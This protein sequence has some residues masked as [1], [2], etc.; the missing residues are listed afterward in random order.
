MGVWEGGSVEVWEG[1][2][3]SQSPIKGVLF[4]R[5]LWTELEKFEIGYME[6]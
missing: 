4:N 1:G 2:N 5:S 3:H 6:L